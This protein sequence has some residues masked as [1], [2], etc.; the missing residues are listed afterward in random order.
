MY[1]TNEKN[2]A[3][4]TH[5]SCLSQY[6]T[7]FGNFIIPLLIWN[8]KKEGSDFIDYNGK[9]VLNFQ[10]SILVYSIIIALIAIPILL[11]TILNTIPPNTLFNDKYYFINHLEI[12]SFSGVVLFATIA[13]LVL[14]GLKFAEFLLIIYASLKTSNGNIY[15]YPLTISFLK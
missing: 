11:V 12:N 5:L 10:L 1:T 14:I 7:P 13:I 9:Q 4:Y 15:K 6:F 8:S 3:T 2:I